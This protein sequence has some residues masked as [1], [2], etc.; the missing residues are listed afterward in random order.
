MKDKFRIT[1][2][3]NKGIVT[4]LDNKIL[5]TDEFYDHKGNVYWLVKNQKNKNVGFCMAT[6]I[7]DKI[8]FL[9]RAGLL[10]EARGNGLHKRMIRVRLNWARKNGFNSVITYVAVDNVQSSRHLIKC[11]FELYLP[12]YSYAGKTYNYFLYP[13]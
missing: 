10:W 12:E 8:V 1:R 11:G 9:S 5:P 7:G 4:D 13:L 6:N 2:T 3:H